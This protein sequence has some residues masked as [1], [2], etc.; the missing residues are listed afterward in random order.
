MMDSPVPE[1]HAERHA[2]HHPRLQHHFDSLGQ[3]KESATLG[4][5]MFLVTEIMFFGGLFTAYVVYRLAFPRVFAE[6]SHTLNPLIGGF[7][8][9]VLIC[10]S[11]TMALAIWAAQL[12]KRKLIVL[13]LLLTIALGAVFLGVKAFEYRE[14][15]EHHLVPGAHFAPDAEHFPYLQGEARHQ[16]QIFFALYFIMTGMHALHMVIGICILA[17]LAWLAWKGRFDSTYYNPLE[18]TGLY[19]HFVDIVW[20]FLFPLLYLIGAHAP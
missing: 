9:A 4:M 6:A 10:S 8:T 14:K 18:C 16:S 15:F 17:V 13:F 3:Q 2:E 5:W 20:I 12:D 1:P 11:L 7:N 19:W